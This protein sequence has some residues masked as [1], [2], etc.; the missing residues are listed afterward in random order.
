[1]KLQVY[2][3]F[4]VLFTVAQVINHIDDAD[5][6]YGYYEPL[7]YLL[8]GKGMQTWEYGPD[9][10]IRSYAFLM[11]FYAIASTFK[12]FGM[13]KVVVF[14]LLRAVIGQITAASLSRLLGTIKN[15]FGDRVYYY[16]IVVSLCCPGLFYCSTS[17]LPSALSC[18]IVMLA[19]ADYLDGNHAWTVFWGCMAVLW[20]GWPFVGVI[21]LPIGLHILYLRSAKSV[22]SVVQIAIQGALLLVAVAVAVLAVDSY[23]Y[24]KKTFPPL[25]ILLYNALSGNGD[26]LYG[27]EP[28]SY[29]VK[30]LLLTLGLSILM[31]ALGAVVVA[32]RMA[33]LPRAI[34][35]RSE[36]VVLLISAVMWI[37]VL[38]SRPHKVLPI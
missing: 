29:Y 17:F 21:F 26:E 5:E 10:A 37:G 27:V 25:N 8:Y 28:A 24:G 19:V 38:M 31:A 11:P 30:N 1:M 4:S 23:L 18:S 13:N 6:T 36:E 7:H 32:Y 33:F 9:F 14:F 2:L 34:V 35:Y 16:M 20:T 3:I 12:L 15:A 22:G